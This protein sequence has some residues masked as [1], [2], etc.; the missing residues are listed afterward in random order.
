MPY[1]VLANGVEISK[2]VMGR[3]GTIPLAH[4]AGIQRYQVRLANGTRFEIPVAQDFSN[5]AKGEL[6]NQGL[7]KLWDDTGVIDTIRQRYQ[8]L[9]S[10]A[11]T[12]HQNQEE[13]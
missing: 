2:G 4:E 5:P 3:D 1:S 6:A 10:T 13:S 12:D 11:A 7:P 8:A 9:L